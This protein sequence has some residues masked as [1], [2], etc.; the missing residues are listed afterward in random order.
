[1]GPLHIFRFL[2]TFCMTILIIVM[3]RRVAHIAPNLCYNL[4][5]FYVLFNLFNLLFYVIHTFSTKVHQNLTTFSS[6]KQY[7]ES[8]ARIQASLMKFSSCSTKFLIYQ[9]LLSFHVLYFLFYVYCPINFHIYYK[10]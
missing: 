9:K 4:L 3:P 5:F 1:M 2:T 6:I 8:G 7:I 10:V